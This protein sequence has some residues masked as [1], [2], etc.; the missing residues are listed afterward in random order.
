MQY[1]SM[2][3]PSL[4]QQRKVDD[5]LG[6]PA[7]LHL[8][9]MPSEDVKESSLLDDSDFGI[10]DDILC[11]IPIPGDCPMSMR[12]TSN[13][14]SESFTSCVFNNCSFNLASK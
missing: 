4:E 1:L 5:I 10:P 7:G 9:E 14:V 12:G 3:R 2:R 11:N 8:N 13:T 6:P